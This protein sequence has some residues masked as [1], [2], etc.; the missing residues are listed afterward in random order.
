M[1]LQFCTIFSL[2]F[3]HFKTKYRANVWCGSFE[4]LLSLKPFI[5]MTGE[6]KKWNHIIHQCRHRPQSKEREWSYFRSVHGIAIH[7]NVV[8]TVSMPNVH[9]PQLKERQRER[10]SVGFATHYRKSVWL[11]PFLPRSFVLCTS[12][13][14]FSI[15]FA[16]GL[17]HTHTFMLTLTINKCDVHRLMCDA[18]K[19]IIFAESNEVAT[20]DSWKVL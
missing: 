14:L 2:H 8:T 18:L 19:F 13:F 15:H 1:N 4:I 9:C 11:K 7:K 20:V 16:F 6:K 12:L 17:K 10:E 3:V 5:I